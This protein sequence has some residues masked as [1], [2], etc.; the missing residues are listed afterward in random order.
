MASSSFTGEASKASPPA[1]HAPDGGAGG[2]KKR[3]TRGARACVECRRKKKTCEGGGPPC[4]RCH[5]SGSV[6][7]FDK[8]SS[9]IIE[10]AGITRLSSIEAALAANDQRLAV[11]SQSMGEFGS[12]L[13]EVLA[14]IRSS[15]VSQQPLQ[16]PNT[17]P[18]VRSSSSFGPAAPL[19][20]HSGP[21]LPTSSLPPTYALP[22]PPPPPSTASGVVAFQPSLDTA[23]LSLPPF[24]SAILPTVPSSVHHSATSEPPK[25]DFSSGLDALASL[26][27]N[28]P[29][30]HRFA[31][32]MGQP[33]S[34]L[35]D[36]V[37]QLGDGEDQH[38]EEVK[39][40]VVAGGESRAGIENCAEKGFPD[41]ERPA[42]RARMA[43]PPPPEAQP[44]CDLVSKGLIS[45]ADAR[46]AVS[47]WMSQ[48]QPFCSVLNPAVDTY[49]SVRRR[50]AFLL[51]VVVYTAL[52]AQGGNAP[53]SQILK[54]AAEETKR[55]ARNAVFKPPLLEDAQA[56]C[57]MACYHQEPYILSGMG[58]RL[59]LS[60]RFETT[61]AQIEE[62]GFHQTDDKAQR[63]ASQFRCW[64]YIL[65][66]DTKHSR[67]SGRLMLVQP[68]DLETTIQQADRFLSLPGAIQTDIRNVANLRLVGIERQISQ[69]TARMGEAGLE[70][71]LEYLHEIRGRITEWH[72]Q[73]DHVLSQ[74]EPSPL[75]WP[76]RSHSRMYWDANLFLVV[77]IFNQH[78]LEGSHAISKDLEQVAR[79]GLRH[80][81]TDLQMVLASPVYRE[82]MRWSGYLLRV[83]LSFAAIFLLKSA[84]AYPHLVNRDEVATEVQQVADLL[85]DLAGS[86]RYSSLLRVA[87][88]QYLARAAP[89][90]MPGLPQDPAGAPAS[91]QSI[92]GPPLPMLPASVSS[93]G[94]ATAS[95]A[96]AIASSPSRILSPAT[97]P[98][99]PTSAPVGASGTAALL[100]GELDFDW[101]LTVAPSLLDD[102]NMLLNHDW[103]QLTVGNT[104]WLDEL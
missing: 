55:F 66:L 81:R 94:M 33:I 3:G 29:D 67:Y 37:A 104:G 45:D 60:A 48:C 46:A 44:R 74:S 62:H 4:K 43:P 97:F 57:I 7:V 100:P 85:H 26:A 99:A 87:R 49:D 1:G 15:G 14:Y 63:L 88:E 12:A 6:C 18:H 52:R 89:S 101:S 10:D 22:R 96:A 51:N 103:T 8:P 82:G 36:A 102:P 65:Q 35:A 53:P 86:Q 73:Y 75:G 92:L 13:Q 27:S 71:R 72:A 95:S 20:P 79:D 16:P 98:N 30:I 76:R 68:G 17:I 47:L 42:K 2:E 23:A 84:A 24:S 83:D 9:A 59:A 25:A 21:T 56:L 41:R 77:S 64:L 70:Q 91:L 93:Y 58:L 90:P 61:W 31:T 54:D 5:T 28:S 80:A 40:D 38:G 11:L 50:S 32:R 78:L 39:A 69:D 34:A 19:F